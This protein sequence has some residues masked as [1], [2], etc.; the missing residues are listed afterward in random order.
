[1]NCLFTNTIRK[2]QPLPKGLSLIPLWPSRITQMSLS[3]AS[4]CTQGNKLPSEANSR[5][6]SEPVQ[7][8]TYSNTGQAQQQQRLKSYFE[9]KRETKPS[10]TPIKSWLKEPV[11]EQPWTS[12][13]GHLQSGN[14]PLLSPEQDG[15]SRDLDLLWFSGS[16]VSYAG[17]ESSVEALPLRP[18]TFL[19]GSRSSFSSSSSRS[20]K[21]ASGNV[22]ESGS[23]EQE[24]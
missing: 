14:S 20:E 12:L 7:K 24:E 11:R 17:S 19:T 15:M 18:S 16:T 13:R 23:L 21:S 10:A 1:M 3:Q 8:T 6:K 5:Q 9:K 22:A 2:R 4:P